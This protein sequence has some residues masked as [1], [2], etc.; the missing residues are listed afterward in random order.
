MDARE[1]AD[2]LSSFGFAK[3][4]KGLPGD[5]RA[6]LDAAV[7]REA[8]RMSPEDVA[9]VLVGYH[10]AGAAPEAS[11][12]L[13]KI[14]KFSDPSD[15]VDALA[16]FTSR[17]VKPAAT[18]REALAKAVVNAAPAMRAG[19]VV[20]TLDAF[21][22]AGCAPMPPVAGDA[23]GRAVLRLESKWTPRGPRHPSRPVPSARRL[24]AT[25]SELFAERASRP[26]TASRMRARAA[27]REAPR[28]T[29]K[30]IAGTLEGYADAGESPPWSVVSACVD[31][32]VREAANMD[33][34]EIADVVGAFALLFF[35][36]GG[37]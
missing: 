2:V 1:I 20:K 8:S 28:F 23:L 19:D 5:A 11:G 7:T 29:P 3:P 14:A 22:D 6:A 9:S 34:D 27:A 12:L 30:N 18:T 32:C 26:R 15:A 33:A 24:S 10:R 4:N 36:F 31:G 35:I 16:V 13:Q 25:R 37:V 17:R 21:A